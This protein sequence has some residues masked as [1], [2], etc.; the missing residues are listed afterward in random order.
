MDEYY[1]I[2]G[3]SPSADDEEIEKAYHELRA[4]YSKDRF[5]E[6]EEGNIAAKN[7]S[8]VEE[9]YYEITEMRKFNKKETEEKERDRK[10]LAD[11]AEAIKK[12]DLDNAQQMLSTIETKGAEWH[13]L[14]SVLYYKRNWI[15]ESRQQLEI[16]VSMEPNNDKY[17]QALQKLNQKANYDESRFHSGNSNH[18]ANYNEN[19][20][21]QMGGDTCMD[22]C[23]AYC[24]TQIFMDICCGCR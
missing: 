13:Y 14:Q 22:C 10:T 4:K 6:G 15:N 19:Y 12:G 23:T 24:C 9:A 18:N 5:L 21:R 3:I 20:N 16:A 2:L 8:K 1:K 11:V 7:L 17:R